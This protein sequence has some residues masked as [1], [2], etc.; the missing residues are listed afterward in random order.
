MKN[1][2]EFL[3]NLSGVALGTLQARRTAAVGNY[4]P[5]DMCHYDFFMAR[6]EFACDRRVQA[7]WNSE[8]AGDNYLLE[9]LSKVVRC[10]VKLAGGLYKFNPSY[11]K[12]TDFNAVVD[13]NDGSDLHRLPFMF[14]TAEGYYTLNERQK[15]NLKR[16]LIQGGFL[17]MDDCAFND[18]GDYFYQSSCRLLAEL[19]G[20]GAVK[21]IGT[22]HE[23]FHNLYDLSRIGL[24]FLQGQNHGARG[25]FI[26]DR[27]AVF[28][29]STD[30]HCGWTDR[31]QTWFG[32][33]RRIPRYIGIH[34][35]KEAIMMGINL[36]IYVLSH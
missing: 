29:S 31:D 13:L 21:S 26:E 12:E 16:Y 6:V 4:I 23:I 11:G 20:K 1:R 14:M 15:Q 8:P 5:P 18:S 30:L 28:L 36:I 32:R 10:K 2:R 33:R 9:E 17:L 24:P 35:Y 27:L 7:R 19:F 3:R 34:S 25:V 22:D